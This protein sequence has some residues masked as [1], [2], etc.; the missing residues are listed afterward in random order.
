MHEDGNC[1]YVG[2]YE[3]VVA[4]AAAL[5][6]AL[7]RLVQTTDQVIDTIGPQL[8]HIHEPGVERLAATSAQALA[9][10]DAKE[11]LAR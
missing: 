2:E 5:R 10:L 8:E 6:A 3:Q 9:L 7:R 11:V 4:E 1:P